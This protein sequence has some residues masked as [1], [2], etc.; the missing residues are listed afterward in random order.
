VLPR[1]VQHHVPRTLQHPSFQSMIQ[2]QHWQP[3]RLLNWWYDFLFRHSH[4]SLDPQCM[5]C[6]IR[7]WSCYYGP[8]CRSVSLHCSR[9]T[10]QSRMLLRSPKNEQSNALADQEKGLSENDRMQLIGDC[11][12][13]LG[14]YLYFHW[15]PMTLFFVDCSPESYAYQGGCPK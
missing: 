14:S 7:Y 3:E 1:Q 4:Q 12:D 10:L 11:F 9:E 15:S 8:H 13:C 5:D 2:Y 6:E